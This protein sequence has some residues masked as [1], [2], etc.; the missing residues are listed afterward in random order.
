[1]TQKMEV[2]A[3]PKT[4][5]LAFLEAFH[6][7]PND[8]D[9]EV[10]TGRG[11]RGEP[12]ILVSIGASRHVLFA[13]EARKIAEVMEATMN[14]YPNEPETATLPNIIMVLRAG[15]DEAQRELDAINFTDEASSP[16]S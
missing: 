10:R 5:V 15:A 1:M 4:R 11:E 9:I 2:A 7:A 3:S 16:V 12:A 6:E 8:A 13:V 14:E